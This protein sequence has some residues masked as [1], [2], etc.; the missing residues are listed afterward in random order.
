VQ[1]KSQ[2]LQIASPDATIRSN[3]KEAAGVARE[4]RDVRARE[5]LEL[6]RDRGLRVT[7]QR[8]WVLVAL[9]ASEDHLSAED[10]YD[11]VRAA[12]PQVDR[13]TIH[14]TLGLFCHKG[15]AAGS[16]LGDGR[17]EYH[18]ENNSRHHHL[19]CRKCGATFEEEDSL[20]EPLREMLVEK[21]GFRVS[22]RHLAII[23]E[24]AK[25]RQ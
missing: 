12:W 5:A 6:L 4:E 18:A 11:Y 13:S 9:L 16:D 25:C 1:C 19:I 23:G 24:C 10:V 22:L 20:V 8:V 14:R 21:C 17:T 15:L 3:W 2:Q 7:P